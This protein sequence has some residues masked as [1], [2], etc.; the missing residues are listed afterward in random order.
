MANIFFGLLGQGA[1]FNTKPANEQAAVQQGISTAVKGLQY[2]VGSGGDTNGAVE[3][4]R[5]D[6]ADAA[7]R[8]AASG[9]TGQ[10]VVSGDFAQ[11]QAYNVTHNA[12]S[13]ASPTDI[14]PDDITALINIGLN[15]A[16]AGFAS[17][18]QSG[19]N[20]NAAINTG[21]EAGADNAVRYIAGDKLGF[22]VT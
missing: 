10:G 8:Y 5:S 7:G 4:V 20:V 14:T 6:V 3:L 19:G 15:S 9:T 17:L 12:V 21:L 22:T 2:L 16:S 18:Q 11:R 1:N 13:N